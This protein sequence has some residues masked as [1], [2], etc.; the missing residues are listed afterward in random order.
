MAI[1]TVNKRRTIGGVYIIPDG[2]IDTVTERKAVLYIYHMIGV[3]KSFI[4]KSRDSYAT[5]TRSSF[6]TKTRST[7][8]ADSA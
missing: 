5:K 4:T 2:A 3:A 1:N 8:V 6:V 7:F